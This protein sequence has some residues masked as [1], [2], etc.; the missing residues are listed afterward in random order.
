MEQTTAKKAGGGA[1]L[2]LLFVIAVLLIPR[3]LGGDPFGS[4]SKDS[5]EKYVGQQ[6][7][8][9][10]GIV[11]ERYRTEVIYKDGDTR[12]IAVQFYTE[13]AGAAGGSFCVYCVAGTVCSSTT[14]MGSGYD[15][16]E[17]LPE[18]KALFGL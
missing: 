14:M 15:Y 3:W 10:L 9:S 6:V 1:V 2:S 13:G 12:L 17:A 5:A 11:C 4:K 16:E 7:Y 8:R 18:L